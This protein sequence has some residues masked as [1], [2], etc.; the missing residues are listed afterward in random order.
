MLVP[1]LER[2]LYDQQLF[3]QTRRS[4]NQQVEDAN[5]QLVVLFR[6]LDIGN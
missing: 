4:F 6:F 5:S 2:L 1:L 3:D